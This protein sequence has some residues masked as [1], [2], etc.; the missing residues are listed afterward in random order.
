MSKPT[1]RISKAF[2]VGGVLAVAAL[3]L[4]QSAKADA[5]HHYTEE[6]VHILQKVA[7]TYPTIAH[8]IHLSGTVIL[9]MD[10]AEDGS[11]DGAS[12]VSGNPIL[13]NGAVTAAK[14]WKF[15]PVTEDGKPVK[16]TVRVAFKFT[17]H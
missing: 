7:P 17:E 14:R 8:Q 10:V 2:Q 9:D 13:S 11:V 15:A 16:A 4:G 3:F 5:G 12:V 6:D 1:L